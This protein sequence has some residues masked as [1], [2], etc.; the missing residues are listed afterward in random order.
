MKENISGKKSVVI[1]FSKLT[2]YFDFWCDIVMADNA[3]Q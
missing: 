3:C 1:D 2:F